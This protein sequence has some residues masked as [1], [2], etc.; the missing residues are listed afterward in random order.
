MRLLFDENTPFSL[1]R[2]LIGHESSSVIRLQW[3]GT[4]NGELLTR[5]EKGVLTL[6]LHWTTTWSQSRTWKVD[7]SP[8][9]F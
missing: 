4:E 3:R 7:E 2:E 9:W 1:A 8:S 5:A 6:S